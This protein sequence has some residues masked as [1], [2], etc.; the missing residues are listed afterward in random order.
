[1]ELI[2]DSGGKIFACKLAMDMFNLT[3]TDL[4]D[5]HDGILTVGDFYNQSG[6]ERTKI[7]FT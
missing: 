4:W 2:S 5:R 1:L 7:I 6:G 3:P